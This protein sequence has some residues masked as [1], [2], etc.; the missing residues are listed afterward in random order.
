MLLFFVYFYRLTWSESVFR[1]TWTRGDERRGEPPALLQMVLLPPFNPDVCFFWCCSSG[2]ALFR[3]QDQT[4]CRC[5]SS[6][7]RRMR[8]DRWRHVFGGFGFV[9]EIQTVI[10]QSKN[11]RHVRSSW[12]QGLVCAQI[13][14]KFIFI[15]F[16]VMT[17]NRLRCV[18][19]CVCV[20]VKGGGRRRHL[21]LRVK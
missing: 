17:N 8:G 16:I 21:R 15:T 18:Y 2:R 10:N 5:C 12:T 20:C 19:A 13:K 6:V 7:K 11:K 1:Y 3:H 4:I 9:S 14:S